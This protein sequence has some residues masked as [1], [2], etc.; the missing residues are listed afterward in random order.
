[1][2]K[3]KLRAFVA[4]SRKR[5]TGRRRTLKILSERPPSLSAVPPFVTALAPLARPFGMEESRMGV[6]DELGEY[7]E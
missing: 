4:S 5:T 2:E 6:V 7:S 1:M 3:G